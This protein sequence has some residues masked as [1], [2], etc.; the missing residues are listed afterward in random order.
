MNER[1][2]PLAIQQYIKLAQN[3]EFISFAAGLPDVCV[4]PLPQLKE[5]Y[6]Q[7]AEEGLLSFQYQPPVESLKKKIQHMMAD[8]SVACELD[9]ILIINGA[10]QGIYLTANLWFK[11]KASLMIEEFVYPG[12]LQVANLFDL[13]Y[14]PIPSKSYEGLDLDYLETVLKT[15][16]PLPY[17]YVVCNGHNPKGISWNTQLR[18][19]LA[20]L[21]EKYNFIIIEDDPYGYLN[22]S[23]ETL[24]PMRAYTK[25]AIYIGSFSKIIAP[26]LRVGWIVGDKEIIQ[27]LEQLKDMNDLYV[28]NPNQLI[29]NKFLDNYSLSEITKPQIASYKAKRDCM[30]S[31]LQKHMKIPFNYVVPSHGM[32]IWLEFP[33]TDIEQ[34]KAELFKKAKVLFIPASAFAVNQSIKKQAMRLNFTYSSH[35]EIIAGVKQLSDAM[36]DLVVSPSKIS[37]WSKDRVV[38]FITP[39]GY[40][41]KETRAV[42][43]LT[44]VYP[45]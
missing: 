7:I 1:I 21:A 6:K 24:L 9:E 35:D 2:K 28:S 42:T 37:Q 20:F 31:A 23:D 41:S 27:K 43:S 44:L 15:Q 32:F 19:D 14:L 13:N 4:L 17:L 34:H 30:I 45:T 10:Q 36:Y 5:M 12:F 18:K 38:D 26:A 33:D 22:F 11:E 16:T 29:L 39:R 25:N 8:K 3:K 40:R